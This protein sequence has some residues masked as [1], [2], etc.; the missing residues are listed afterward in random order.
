[1]NEQAENYTEAAIN[2][3]SRIHFHEDSKIQV[4]AFIL[5]LGNAGF[6]IPYEKRKMLLNF[7]SEF[8]D[9]KTILKVIVMPV[10]SDMMAIS[11][12]GKQAT[13][14][15][16]CAG[17]KV[18]VKESVVIYIPNCQPI[19]T[20]Y[21]KNSVWTVSSLRVNDGVEV[22]YVKEGGCCAIED[23]IHC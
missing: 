21:V 7:E 10:L 8:L 18:K 22:A 12:S 2:L 14:E 3:L 23:F 16:T 19:H 1:M 9:V 17:D 20:Q 11:K 6:L 5:E 13:F 4:K 15:N